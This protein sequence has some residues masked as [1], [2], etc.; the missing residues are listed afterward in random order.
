MKFT[1]TGFSAVQRDG[2]ELS[3]S[4]TARINADMRVGGLEETIKVTGETPVVD[5]QSTQQERVLDRDH[6]MTAAEAKEWGLIDHV[7]TSRE[8]AM[9]AL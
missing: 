6:F 9:L 5:V 4:F 1:L 8:A 7:Y 3:G 2:V